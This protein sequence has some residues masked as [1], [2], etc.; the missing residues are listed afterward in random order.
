MEV[1][2]SIL[3]QVEQAL[4]EIRPFLQKDGGD[5]ELL[6]VTKD[7]IAK[8]S[9]LGACKTCNMNTMTFTAGVEE[10]IKRNVPSIKSVISV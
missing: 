10:S 5:V 7:N 3:E 6:E 4:N 1:N 8:V 9:F 2:S